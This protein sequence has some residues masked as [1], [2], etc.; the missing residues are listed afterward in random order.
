M[1]YV[2]TAER[3]GLRKG[4]HQGETKL[5]LRQME[6]RFGTVPKWAKE[7]IEQADI[8]AIEDWGIRLLSADSPE[9]MLAEGG[10]GN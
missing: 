2:T 1:Q 7:R 10:N 5:L 9:E 6:A 3:I 4:M 8:N